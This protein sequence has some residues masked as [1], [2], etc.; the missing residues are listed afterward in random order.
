MRP[1]IWTDDAGWR[2]RSWLRD[3]DPDE[4]APRG[5]PD[6]PPDV[7]AIDMEAVRRA[8]HNALV[9]QELT[10]WEAVQRAPQ[11]LTPAI[12]AALRPPLMALYR[13][14]AQEKKTEQP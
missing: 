1:L 5:V 6:E 12:L 11:G 9:E 2:H 14:A 3:A 10:S 13:Q 7:H 4:M 8:L